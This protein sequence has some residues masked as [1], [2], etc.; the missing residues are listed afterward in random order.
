MSLNRFPYA[1]P[2]I[3]SPKTD[4]SDPFSTLGKQYTQ[5]EEGYGIDKLEKTRVSRT[6]SAGTSEA[7]PFSMRIPIRVQLGLLV[8][9]TS[10]LAL[11]VIS[12]AT[13]VYTWNFVA[14]IK[15]QGLTLAASL[16]AAQIASDLRL[17]QTTCSTIVT[18]ILIQQSLVSFYS[19]GATAANWSAAVTDVTSALASG[20]YSNLLQVIIYPRNNTGND[21][22][23]LNVTA[24]TLPA[25]IVLPYLYD[26]GSVSTV[27]Q[28]VLP[29]ELTIVVCSL[30]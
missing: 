21:H 26:N 20:G 25:P 13:W 18:R 27:C 19:S 24:S 17:I 7:Q 8:L 30:R 4:L 14:N 28:N 5:E 6:I 15:S 23:L 22:G 11:A 12:I 3:P 29:L 9:L 16:K 1:S 2:S 10:T